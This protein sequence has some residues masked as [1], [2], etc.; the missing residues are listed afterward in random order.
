[1]KFKNHYPDL[2]KSEL[3][4]AHKYGIKRC[5]VGSAAFKKFGIGIIKWAVDLDDKLWIIPKFVEAQF[6]DFDNSER[7]EIKHSVLVG[8]DEVQAAGEAEVV[9]DSLLW[10][11]NDSGHY[12]PSVKSV[13]TGIDAFYA[14]GI[15]VDQTV[16]I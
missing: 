16:I 5:Q 1:M 3:A 2:L 8:G 4:E 13:Q 15:N 11:S 6:L 12:R 9:D 10:I 7:I 14:A